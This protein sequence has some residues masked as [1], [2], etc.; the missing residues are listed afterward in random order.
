MA[1]ELSAVPAYR[2]TMQR[3][4]E[5]KRVSPQGVDFWIAREVHLLLGYP[6]FDKFLPVIKR[7]EEAFTGNE[8]DASHHIAQTSVMMKVGKGAQRRHVDYFLS[9]AACYL[10]AMNGDPSK[11]EI[12]GAQAY[13]AIQTRAAELTE[14]EHKDRKRLASRERVTT[15]L[16]RV[17]DVAKDVGVRRYDLFHAARY[18]GLYGTTV[19]EVHR[20]KGLKD[21]EKLLDRAPALELSAHAFQ[22]D[23]AREK[24]LNE[25][26][27]GEEPAIRANLDVARDVRSLVFQQAGVNLE[28]IALEPE[29]IQEVKK[30]LAATPKRL[31]R[32]SA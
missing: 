30:R 32:P 12:A 22:S 19:S 5:V 18:H 8:L 21:G 31:S 27:S 1:S 2:H 25:G 28:D 10:I 29:P 15:A 20:K 13:F 26:I 14:Q 23:L 6:V 17:S 9:R 4:E 7:A 11:P 16:K 3:L 24:I